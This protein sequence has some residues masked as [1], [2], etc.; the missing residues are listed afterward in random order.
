MLVRIGTLKW[1]HAAASTLLAAYLYSPSLRGS[2]AY[3]QLL[4]VV[5]FPAVAGLGL[6]LWL[7]PRIN[8]ALRL[9]GA[10]FSAPSEVRRPSPSASRSQP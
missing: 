4:Q 5:V 6:C 10:S 3:L 8:R 9:R 7:A 2:E 1:A